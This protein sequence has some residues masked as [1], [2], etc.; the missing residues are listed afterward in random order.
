M[1]IS[2]TFIANIVTTLVFVLPVFGIEIVD[3]SSLTDTITKLIA[4]G[5]TLYV[6]YGRYKAGG[7]SAFGFRLKK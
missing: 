6:F 5:T 1:N 3:Q 7:I 2:T 4:V